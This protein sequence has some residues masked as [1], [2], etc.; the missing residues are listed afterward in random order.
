MCLDRTRLKFGCSASVER[1]KRIIINRINGFL[2]IERGGE[3][4]SNF[5]NF[6]EGVMGS[7]QLT[8][9]SLLD[10]RRGEADWPLPAATLSISCV[11]RRWSFFLTEE[12][13][14][15]SLFIRRHRGHGLLLSL[16]RVR[17]AIS[18]NDLREL[19]KLHD[20]LGR[21]IRYISVCS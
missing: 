21:Q 10:A 13:E 16:C 11:G 9:H 6:G 5:R 17:T 20:S 15:R 1:I 3:K 18:L 7:H 12:K 2:K 14:S 4:G 8:A 19:V